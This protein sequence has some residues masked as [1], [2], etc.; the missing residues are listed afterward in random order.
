[1]FSRKSCLKTFFF[2][3][4]ARSGFYLENTSGIQPSL[5]RRR[6]LALLPPSPC[7]PLPAPAQGAP[8]RP[9]GHPHGS[10]RSGPCRL[11]A[12]LPSLQPSPRPPSRRPP[13]T[14]LPGPH[15][16]LHTSEHELKLPQQL[17]QHLSPGA[18]PLEGSRA[19]ALLPP[20]RAAQRSD[21]PV[22]AALAESREQP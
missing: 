10:V 9:S 16:F 17:A 8:Q 15:L 14:R 3:K 1:M 2:K 4:Y 12:A 22:D 13:S 19:S 21:R 5:S 11:G 18:R 20:E 6:P 7:S